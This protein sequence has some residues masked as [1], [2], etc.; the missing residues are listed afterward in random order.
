M[1]LFQNESSCKTFLLKIFD[2]HENEPVGQ[3]HFHI[4][5]FARSLVLTQRGTATQKWRNGTPLF[6]ERGRE[7]WVINAHATNQ[8]LDIDINIYYLGHERKVRN[9]LNISPAF[10]SRTKKLTGG[11]KAA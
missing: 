5:L 1:P 6:N 2:L 7:G 8:D 10:R 9:Q 11:H 4:K 3:T